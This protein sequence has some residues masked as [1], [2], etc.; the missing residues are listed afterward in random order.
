MKYI[1]IVLTLIILFIIFRPRRKKIGE[2][3]NHWNHYFPNLQFSTAE[4]YA[5]V[6]G[7]IRDQAM[8]EVKISRVNF[9]ESSIISNRREYLHV[10]RKEDIFDICAAPFGTGFFV[11]YWQGAPSHSFRDW[12]SKIPIL[13]AVVAS[14]QRTTYY[15]IDT[16]CMFRG[17][18]V[19]CIQ[20]AIEE[21][22]NQKGIRGMTENELVSMAQ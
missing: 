3:G 15:K 9:A 14:S 20:G 6:E 5:L 2:V 7:K 18:V 17:L 10:E 19:S 22:S 1:L 21:M 16:A 12:A 13:G 4:Y 8:S 11:S